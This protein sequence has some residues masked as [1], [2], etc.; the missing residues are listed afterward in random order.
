MQRADSFE[1][2]WCWERLKAGGERDDRAWDGWMDMGLSKLRE[3]LTDRKAW[4]AAV[5]GVTKSQTWLSD[6]TE[7]A[8][9][10]ETYSNLDSR[11]HSR[12]TSCSMMYVVQH[13]RQGPSDSDIRSNEVH[14][15]S[16]KNENA[17][18][19]VFL[20]AKRVSQ[21]SSVTHLSRLGDRGWD[22]WMVSSTWWENSGR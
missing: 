4:R 15:F 16:C 18:I 14:I 6:W 13:W 22:S 3:L 20:G 8:G 17:T 10:W 11:N 12:L 5:H 2:A 19:H 21:T 7:L 9:N 1:R